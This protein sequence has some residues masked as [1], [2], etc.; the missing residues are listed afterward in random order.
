MPVLCI[1]EKVWQAFVGRLETLAERARLLE[2][3]Y[4]PR[5]DSS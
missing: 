5:T 3:R 2:H 4:E 1:D